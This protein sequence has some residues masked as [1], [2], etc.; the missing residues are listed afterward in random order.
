MADSI[1]AFVQKLQQEGVQAGR[2]EAQKL[3]GEAQAEAER[4]VSEAHAEAERI[5]KGAKAEAED[6]LKQGTDELELAARDALLRLRQ[7]LTD[8]LAALLHRA[9]AEALA[10]KG[11]LTKLLHDVVMQ[12]ARK[13]A[14]GSHPIEIHVSDEDLEAVTNWALQEM[15][16]HEKDGRAHID[17][18]GRLKSAG[19]EYSAGGGTVEVT[20]ESISG[21]LSEM[22]APRLR[23][24]VDKAAGQQE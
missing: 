16:Q 13:D 9:S 6:K 23:E 17:L 10:E 3:M 7:T 21:V 15:T 18:K 2:T 1:E 20:P 14:E 19:F 24:V 11:F 4:I 5:V 22:I 8:A 12:Y